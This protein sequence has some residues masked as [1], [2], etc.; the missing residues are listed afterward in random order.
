MNKRETPVKVG[1]EYTA[2]IE[3]LNSQAEGVARIEGFAVFVRSALPGEK[4][5]LKITRTYKNHALAECREILEAASERTIPPCEYYGSCGGC[6]LQHL[7]YPAQLDYKRR[8]VEDA[9]RRIGEITEVEVEPTVGMAEPWR[10]RNKAQ[11]PVGGDTAHPEVGFYA[12]GSHDLVDLA[13]CLIQEKEC[14]RII[15]LLKVHMQR[16]GWQPY[17]EK[18]HS[19]L[20]RH[21]VVK[22][23]FKTGERM[24]I[25]VTN[26]DKLPEYQGFLEYLLE[27]EVGLVSLVQ[28]INTGRGNTILGRKNKLLYGKETISDR[29]G[30]KEFLISP[31]SFYQVNPKQTEKLYQLALELAD[32]QGT[33]TVVD[34]YCGVG[35]IS[36]YAAAHARE[37]I[38]I[39]IVPEAV[40]SAAE[41]ARYNKLDNL[42]FLSGSAEVILPE[43]L[44]QG[45]QPHAV[46]L[47]PPRK[48]CAPELLLAL[49]QTRP[50]KIVYVSCNP[51][52]LARDLKI[53]GE[54]YR[55][56]RVVP[57]DMFPHTG[58]VECVV[59]MCASSEAGKC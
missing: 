46:F 36:M 4:V 49:L 41:N 1:Q 31:L 8:Q 45:I 32:L 24:I 15:S 7:A 22:S 16:F 26:G 9:L 21:L 2:I 11:F 12:L 14:S 38:G 27:A 44:T 57:V 39:E 56:E 50:E 10:Y 59:L 3:N 28:N 35:T 42:R 47:D 48:G 43:L 30:D 6:Q 34:A 19:G 53:L 40:K 52:T 51:A 55:V 37:V 54:A 13:D 18:T 20:L 33:E 17:D 29:I 58:H 25:L 23:S 5:K